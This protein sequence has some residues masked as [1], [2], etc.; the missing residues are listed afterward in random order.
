MNAMICSRI[1]AENLKGFTIFLSQLR[2]FFQTEAI[3]LLKLHRKHTRTI[4]GICYNCLLLNILTKLTTLRLFPLQMQLVSLHPGSYFLNGPLLVSL[5]LNTPVESVARSLY[6]F[7][8]C[9]DC[10]STSLFLICN[11]FNKK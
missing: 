4:C 9:S 1:Y 5:K 10:L 2:F 6:V 3:K 8:N 7:N 11:A